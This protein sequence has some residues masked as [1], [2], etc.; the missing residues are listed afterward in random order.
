MEHLLEL[1]QEY[2]VSIEMAKSMGFTENTT[3]EEAQKV[4]NDWARCNDIFAE[5]NKRIKQNVKFR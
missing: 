4:L 5:E 3:I 2:T 1:F